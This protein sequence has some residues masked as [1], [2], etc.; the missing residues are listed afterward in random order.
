MGVNG[1]DFGLCVEVTNIGHPHTTR[2][3]AEG[4]ILEG[5]EFL[6]AGRKGVRE[7]NGR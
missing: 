7:P 4:G 2:H 1:E 5:Q 3:G 6:D